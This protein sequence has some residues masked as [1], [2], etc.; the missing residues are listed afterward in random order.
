MT[1]AQTALDIMQ[2]I[3]RV[4]PCCN[5]T[6]AVSA[7]TLNALRD[8]VQNAAEEEQIIYR[9]LQ[10]ARPVAAA[11][12]VRMQAEADG[13]VALGGKPNFVSE[14]WLSQARELLFSINARLGGNDD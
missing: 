9:I 5:G 4:V 11:H 8:A 2:T 10:R 6:Q 12:V 3:P 13:A 7:A 14:E 1:P